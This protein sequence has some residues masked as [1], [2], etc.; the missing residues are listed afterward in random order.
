MKRAILFG[1]AWLLG[2]CI[3]D[4]QTRLDTSKWNREKANLAS[5]SYKLTRGCFCLPDYV[6]PFL[7]EATRDSVTRVRRIDQGAEPDTIDV[8][9]SLQSFSIDSLIAETRETLA[10]NHASASVRYHDEYQWEITDFE[11]AAAP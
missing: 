2:G 6:G 10:R 8:T 3:L 9:E 5:Y 1:M 4:P 7:V 11:T